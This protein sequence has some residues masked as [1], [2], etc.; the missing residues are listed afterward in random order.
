[1]CFTKAAFYLCN[2]LSPLSPSV[3][4]AA[5]RNSIPSKLSSFMLLSLLSALSFLCTVIVTSHHWS[6]QHLIHKHT[7]GSRS[8]NFEI[9]MRFYFL[10]LRKR[11]LVY[12][13]LTHYDGL[14]G[15]TS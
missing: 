8:S 5:I 13:V 10:C 9:L 14:N 15:D 11:H 7:C 1:M 3:T 4:A 2:S 6:V 12:K